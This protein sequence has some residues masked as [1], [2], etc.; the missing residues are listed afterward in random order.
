MSTVVEKDL[1]KTKLGRRMTRNNKELRDGRALDILEGLELQYKRAIENME[2]ELKVKRRSRDQN[3]DI[4][5]T[6]SFDLTMNVEDAATFVDKDIKLGVDIRQLELKLE[7]A[8]KQYE[9]MFE[10]ETDAPD[11]VQQN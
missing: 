9:E 3:F 7:V 4:A 5:P 1:K 11:D 6:K 2:M 8:K 10:E